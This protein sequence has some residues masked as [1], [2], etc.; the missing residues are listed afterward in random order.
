VIAIRNVLEDNT[1]NQEVV[2]ALDAQNPVQS[3]VLDKAG[4]RVKMDEYGKVSLS[5]VK[6]DDEAESSS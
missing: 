6:E 4:V 3:A 1:I 2:A 5:P